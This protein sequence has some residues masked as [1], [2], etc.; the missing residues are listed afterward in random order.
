MAPVL[1]SAASPVIAQKDGS[2][3]KRSTLLIITRL[4]FLLTGQHTDLN[5]RL[6][7]SSLVFSDAKTECIDCHTDVHQSSA[8][9]DC[10]RCHTPVS[11]LVENIN[12]LHQVSRFPLLGAHRT[13]DCFDC[14]KSESLARF[15]VPGIECIDCHRQDF[16]A[17]LNPNH[18][19]AG[20]SEDCTSCHPVYAFQWTGVGFNHNFFALEQGHSIPECAECHTSGSYSDLSP[21]CNSC[22]RQDYIAASNPNHSTSN[23]PVTC[24][25][26]HTLNPGWQPASFDHTSFPLTLGHST[27]ECAACHI[28]GNYS[29]ATPD[30][31]SC[32]H[33]DY[34][35]TSNPNHTTS[36]FPVTCEVC[37]SLN[38]GWKPASF[39]HAFFPLT[40]G[41]STPK[42]I[43]CHIGGNYST[44]PTDCYACHQGNYNTTT[45]P[46]HSSLSFSTICTQCHT[47]NPDWKPASYT[48]HDVQSF[49]IYS[50][51]HNGVWNSCTQCHPNTAAYS[52]ISCI[53]CHE[54]NQTEMNT[55]H[56]EVTGYSYNSAACFNC[57]PRG[58]SD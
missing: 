23:F 33:Q 51:R 28:T 26:C 25:I 38:P 7:H 42:C 4:S 35:A 19:Q 18:Q 15:D 52:Q 14:H 53:T 22:H 29:D 44:T 48:Q 27:P 11:W 21:E 12:E 54:H 45:N 40:L 46:N 47:T 57:H 39:D 55:K 50:G 41:H 8:G 5:C 31:N 16:Q 43:D 30:C 13:A 2:S 9:S 20:F 6:C 34:L 24:E 10:A 49:P 3:I 32:H 58:V 36:N 37:H 56:A 17:T 1:K